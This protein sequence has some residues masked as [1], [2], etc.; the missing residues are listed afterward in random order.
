MSTR[1]FWICVLMTAAMSASVAAEDYTLHTFR[2]VTLTDKFY[3]EGAHVGDFNHDGKQ[4]IAAGPFWYEGPDFTAV[5]EY[6]P[7]KAFDPHGY[8]DAFLMFTADFNG[9]KWDDILVV[10]WPGKDA[11]WFENPQGGD[12]HWKQHLAF[13]VVDNESPG[14]GDVTG[15]GRPELVCHTR[16]R[17]GYAEPNWKDPA[18]PWRF[19]PISAPGGWGQYQHGIGYGDVNGD[20]RADMLLREGWWEQPDS[21]GADAPWKRHEVAFSP[22]RGG[23]QML[24]YDVD[25]DG[26]ND[27][28]TSLDAHGYGLVWFE[29]SKA[30]DGESK[31]EQHLIMGSK[32]EDNP[33]GVKFSQLH[34]LFLVDIDG[35]GLQ[36]VVTGKRFWA[37]GPN[38]DV[39]PD[40]PAVLYWFRLT[41]SADKGVEYVPYLVDDDSG[42][43]TQVIAADVTGNG[44]PDIIVGNKKGAFVHLHEKKTVTRDQ[45]LAA[46]PKR[47]K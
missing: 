38:G 26:D 28:V 33:Y 34:A 45:W 2:K 7:A 23:A 1:T 30:D 14:F 31:F 27:V 13:D 16:G 44:L 10:G 17:L 22:G 35:D 15:D 6:R 42:V 37:H 19:Q 24:V 36:D 9:D 43:G 20:G 11:S 41:R 4:D 18:Q 32:P 39:E 3:S 47:L 29:H 25:G 46:Q 40:A 5:H 21:A 8:S 12:G